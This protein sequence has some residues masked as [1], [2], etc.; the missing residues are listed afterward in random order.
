MT[1]AYALRESVLVLCVL[2]IVSCGILVPVPE[3]WGRERER[4]KREGKFT[5]GCLTPHPLA[6]TARVLDS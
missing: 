6:H 4:G 2:S 1:L 3:P 5:A